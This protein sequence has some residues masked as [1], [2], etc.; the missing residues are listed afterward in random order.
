LDVENAC[1]IVGLHTRVLKLGHGFALLVWQFK[2]LMMT[3]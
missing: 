1:T 2:L 3:P